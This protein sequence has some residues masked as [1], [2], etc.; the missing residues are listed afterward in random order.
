MFLKLL[1][2]FCEVVYIIGQIINDINDDFVYYLICYKI[3]N[4]NL[5]YKEISNEKI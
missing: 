5:K 2:V 4:F 1:F 3:L